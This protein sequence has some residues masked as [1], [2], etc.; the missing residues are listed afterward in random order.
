MKSS[1]FKLFVLLIM[2]SF[3]TAGCAASNYDAEIL[4]LKD[5]ISALSEKVNTQNESI[6]SLNNKIIELADLSESILSDVAMLE[7]EEYDGSISLNI[8]ST[9]YSILKNEYGS[10]PIIIDNVEETLTGF[11]LTLRIGN[12]TTSTFSDVAFHFVYP[13]KVSLSELMKNP[14][15][16]NILTYT[17][18]KFETPAVQTTL[19]AG[20]WTNVEFTLTKATLEELSNFYILPEFNSISLIK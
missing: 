9:G 10:F 20:E 5:E 15:R 2:L 17:S 6:K 11:K 13:Q 8:K 4:M 7:S 3:I 18:H 14:R 19:N 16:I 12:M 1:L